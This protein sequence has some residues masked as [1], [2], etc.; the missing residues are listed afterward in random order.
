MRALGTPSL[1]FKS[2]VRCTPGIA[3]HVSLLRS[4]KG[5]GPT[6]SPFF[7]TSCFAKRQL[8]KEKQPHMTHE[9]TASQRTKFELTMKRKRNAV[10]SVRRFPRTNILTPSDTIIENYFDE[11]WRSFGLRQKAE[12]LTSY[13]ERK[14]RA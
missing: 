8:A 4:A 3:V 14:A 9:W 6:P 1:E 13:L 11:V 12:A 2:A 10:K 7:F 5:E